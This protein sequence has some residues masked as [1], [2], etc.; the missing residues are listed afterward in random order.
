MKYLGCNHC[1]H[2]ISGFHTHECTVKTL[3]EFSEVVQIQ[4]DMS[5]LG[6]LTQR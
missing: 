2:V 6:A 3:S 5:A 1:N 4:G